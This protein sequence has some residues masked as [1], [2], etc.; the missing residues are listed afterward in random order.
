MNGDILRSLKPNERAEVERE[1][2]YN[3]YPAGHQFHAPN[4]AGDEIFLLRSGRVRLYKLSTEGRALT[5]TM[6]EPPAAFGEMALA[7]RGV[8][9]SFAECLVESIVGVCGRESLR[10][11]M[12]RYPSVAL[13]LMELMGQRLRLIE[14]KLTDIAFKSVPAR[15]ASLLLSLA[16]QVEPEEGAPTRVVRYTHLQLAEMIGSYRETVTKALGEFREAD[17]IRIDEEAIIL[18]DLLALQQLSQR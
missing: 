14:N 17:L 4:E 2:A 1:I 18:R 11:V 10:G 8:H 16:S 5:L 3:L 6:L 15:L 13:A 9:D 7:E 12:E